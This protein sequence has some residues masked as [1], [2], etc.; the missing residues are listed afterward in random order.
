LPIVF[1]L[2]AID[3]ILPVEIL[4]KSASLPSAKYFAVILLPLLKSSEPLSY[5]KYKRLSVAIALS[6]INVS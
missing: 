3:R 2:I 1:L 4:E 5:L 6:T